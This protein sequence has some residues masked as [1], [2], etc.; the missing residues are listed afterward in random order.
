MVPLKITTDSSLLTSLI[1][2]PDL[3]AF[4]QAHNIKACAICDNNLYASIEFYIKCKEKDIKP[5]I[6][7]ETIVSDKKVYVYAKNYEGYKHLIKLN[8]ASDIKEDNLNNP[9]IKIILPYE[10]YE[11]YSSIIN[12]DNLFLGYNSPIE[13]KNALILTSNVVRVNNARVLD[14]DNI[15]YLKYLQDL[16]GDFKFTEQDFLD[17]NLTDEEEKEQELFIKDID[18]DIPFDKRYIPIYKDNINSYEYL[19]TLAIKGLEKRFANHIP[20]GYLERLEE[21]LNTVRSMGFIDYF[22]IVYDYVLF[23]KKN[24]IIVGPGRGSAAGSLISYAI[25]IIDIDPIKYDLLFARFLNPYRK[26]MPDI[27]IDFEDE[28]R[29]EVIKYVQQRYGKDNVAL[30]LTFNNYKSKL[31]LRDL[32]KVLKID[33]NLFEKFIRIIRADLSLKDNLESNKDIK[34]YLDIYPSLKELYDIA[35]HLEGLKK[36]IST[37][38]AGVVISSKA[39]NEIIPVI[40]DEDILK[41]GIAMDYIENMGLLKMDFLG[42][43]N[44]T[45]IRKMSE[46]I[47]DFNM[48]NIP[49]DDPKVYEYL[50]S[51][52]TEDLFQFESRY[53]S[54]SLYKLQVKNFNELT[55]AVA[56]VR[57][58]PNKQMDEYIKNKDTGKYEVHPDI[59]EVLDSTYGIMI[60]QEQVMKI[61]TIIAGYNGY[62]ADNVRIAMSKKKMDVLAKE[63]DNFIKKAIEKGY[64][65]DFVNDLF[66]KIL[67]FA[68]YS[69]NKSHSVCYAKIVYTLAYLKVNYPVIYNTVMLE[70]A[71]SSESRKYYITLLKKDNITILKPNINLSGEDFKFKNNYL[72]LPFKMIKNLPDNVIKVILTKRDKE[73]NDIYDFILKCKEVLTPAIFETLVLSGALDTF[74]YTKASL[75]NAMDTLFN[76]ASMDDE[77][78]LKPFLENLPEYS[79]ETLMENELKYYG[80]YI[81]NHPCSKYQKVVKAS[82]VKEYLFKNI[83][84]ALLVEKISS[85]K[86]KKGE[87]MAFVT[88]SDETGEVELV[89]FPRV[90]SSLTD[91]KVRDIILINGKSSKK[92]DKY[93]VVVNKLD[94]E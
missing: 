67:S 71:K 84:M 80:M 45:L 7:L 28:R 48:Q 31:I 2:I 81:S 51:G 88:A 77:N 5:I 44:L 54:N 43:R 23:A 82:K 78:A 87:Q 22:L 4:L 59:K 90:Y 1:K 10:S 83:N 36:N 14:K 85:L 74:K 25:G 57:P 58:G 63:K 86:T 61:L 21:E 3:M 19:K 17:L 34:K 55:A 69:F 91:L 92:F 75:I 73:F 38:A 52:K 41:T 30:G 8:S 26:K 35:F 79:K 76:Y 42:L 37:H 50:K 72:L 16:G 53:A 60:Y 9:N 65:K 6:A 15:S 64:D 32:A 46:K 62:E 13:K 66:E 56:L 24:G 93:Q 20:K 11:L 33:N 18:I 89:L 27:D 47:K 49:L 94:R 39:L 70:E 40:N 29:Y 68:S 12:K